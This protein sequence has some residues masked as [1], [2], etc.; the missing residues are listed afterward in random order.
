MKRRFFRVSSLL[1]V[2]GMLSFSFVATSCGEDD[3]DEVVTKKNDVPEYTITY[4]VNGGTGTVDP[5]TF[6]IGERILLPDGSALTP[7][8]GMVF[9]G[10]STSKD[11]LE[12]NELAIKGDQTLYAIWKDPAADNTN[13]Q[14]TF[15]LD[16]GRVA[17]GVKTTIEVEKGDEVDLASMAP[18][19]S[20]FAFKGWA[21]EKGGEVVTE[22]TADAVATLFAVWEQNEWDL[23]KEGFST[24]TDWV[25]GEIKEAAACELVLGESTGQP[26]G[27]PSVNN[28]ID[29]SSYK[30]LVLV[31]SE[32]EP[33]FMLNRDVAEGQAPDHLI[34]I[35]ND[36]DQTAAYETVVDNGD[37]TKTYTVDL[38]KIVSEKGYA[39]LH[40]IKGANWAN[41]TVNSMKVTKEVAAAEVGVVKVKITFELEGGKVEDGAKTTLSVE[42][43]KAVDFTVI[44]PTR[45]DYYLKGWATEK[46][47]EV[48]SEYIADAAAT[49]YA[50]WEKSVSDLTKEGF[51]EWTDYVNGEIKGEAPCEYAIGEESD[52]P[53]G[54]GNVINYID[55]S[56]YKALIVTVSA[57]EPRFLI[58]RDIKD[59]QNPDHLINIPNDADQTAA[60]ETV[61]DNGDGTKTYTIDLVKIIEDWGYAHLHSI[62]GAN[63]AKVTVESM[64]VRK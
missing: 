16:G 2:A 36:P 33:R 52:T 18:I 32:G 57:G 5:T 31:V 56:G 60:Y 37:G 47:G 15:D 12:Y 58:N 55:L 39:H 8:S 50:V 45:P 43:G 30:S 48:V 7:P 11:K 19:K 54:D 41:V 51:S 64:Q 38:A 22:F 40:A 14:I 61:V 28:Y 1:L 26:Y 63:W 13:I 17:D 10:W 27:D 9:G 42:K 34:A 4:D 24:W 29:L 46:G 23:T 25:D 20:G 3:D 49:F 59:G 21:T 6:K 53:Y 44:A 35:P 62:K